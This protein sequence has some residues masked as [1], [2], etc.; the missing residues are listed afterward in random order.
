M[1]DKLWQG[2]FNK[3]SKL[4]VDFIVQLIGQ[5]RTKRELF[6][7]E[8]NAQKPWSISES[9]T[10]CKNPAVMDYVWPHPPTSI[11]GTGCGQRCKTGLKLSTREGSITLLL[12]WVLN[13]YF[14]PCLRFPLGLMQSNISANNVI[15]KSNGIF[16]RPYQAVYSLPYLP[17]E[18]C[19]RWRTQVKK[20]AWPRLQYIWCLAI[21]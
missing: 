15:L 20:E 19:W 14:T 4:V 1:V 16:L 12:S 10:T 21:C 13:S 2:M 11:S 3:D 7:S 5:V 17:A 6:R 8:R 9:R 18:C